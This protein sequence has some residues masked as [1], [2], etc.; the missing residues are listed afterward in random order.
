M[1]KPIK[2]SLWVVFFVLSV[3][4]TKNVEVSKDQA[5]YFLKYFGGSA[6]DKAMDVKCCSDGGYAL[7]G[8]MASVTNDSVAVFIKTDP[9]GNEVNFS[10]VLLGNGNKSI[11]YA[12]CQTSDGSFLVA[13]SVVASGRSDKD[14]LVVK[15]NSDGSLAWTKTFGGTGDDEAYS[16][17][18]LTT[19]EI[20]VGGYTRSYGNGGKDAWGLL[21]D[22]SGN[23]IWDKPY[24]FAGDDVGN[25]FMDKG[26]YFLM[27]GSTESF[28]FA[29]L[30][31]SVFLVKVDKV[32]GNA[33]DFVYYGGSGS[34]SG[35]K[36]LI[37]SESSDIFVLANSVAASLSNIY[38]LRLKDDFHQVVWEKY[39]ASANSE[40]GNDILLNNNQIVVVG[41][42]TVNQ[43]FDLLT[44]IFDTQGNLTNAGRNVL[45]A[46]GNQV[47]Q[48][49]A[50]ATDGKLILAGS[51]VVDGFSKIM[52]AKIDFPR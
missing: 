9:Y 28:Q 2:N 38:L 44:D 51:N 35:V 11:G 22:A 27:V 32:S 34:E 16:V 18:E 39:T 8:T 3:S 47:A 4:C 36:A 30:G 31:R 13:G 20:L 21:L 7:T 19:G 6:T 29:Y 17:T 40:M 33:F 49:G 12:L 46:Q 52:L 10:P 23:K 25:Y 14:V 15:I 48:A 45:S 26:S 43:N 42:S 37:D 41:S 1:P 24:G 5:N 50:I